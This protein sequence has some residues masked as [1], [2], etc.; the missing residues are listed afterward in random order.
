MNTFGGLL[1]LFSLV[2]F[3]VAAYEMWNG[4]DDPLATV[5][6]GLIFLGVGFFLAVREP[7]ATSHVIERLA[8][9]GASQFQSKTVQGAEVRETTKAEAIFSVIQTGDDRTLDKVHVLLSEDP[10]VTAIVEESGR[11]YSTPDGD[12]LPEWFALRTYCDP[13]LVDTVMEETKARIRESLGPTEASK[14]S[15]SRYS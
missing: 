14:V 4:A 13:T 8:S 7:G 12:D 9:E 3:G 1:I 15:I 11:W 6:A 5:F 2:L 10:R